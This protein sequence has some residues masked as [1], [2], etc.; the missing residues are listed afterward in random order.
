[1]KI[2]IVPV[3][4]NTDLSPVYTGMPGTKISWFGSLFGIWI[5]CAVRKILQGAAQVN[6]VVIKKQKRRMRK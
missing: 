4:Q 6:V 1:M 5:A 3:L 2:D